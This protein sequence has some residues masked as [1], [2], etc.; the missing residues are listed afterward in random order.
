MHAPCPHRRAGWSLSVRRPALAWALALMALSWLAPG[1]AVAADAFDG[2]P[3]QVPPVGRPEEAVPGRGCAHGVRCPGA[4][5]GPGLCRRPDERAGHGVCRRAAGGR[6]HP[7]AGRPQPDP[8]GAGTDAAGG[9]ARGGVSLQVGAGFAGAGLGFG[10]GRVACR[11]GLCR[12][13]RRRLHRARRHPRRRQLDPDPGP[14]QWP[15]VQRRARAR[16]Q[17]TAAGAGDAPDGHRPGRRHPGVLCQA[18][19][20]AGCRRPRAGAHADLRAGQREPGVLVRLHAAAAGPA[21]RG[22]RGQQRQ[23]HRQ[24]AA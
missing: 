5:A 4:G 3:V 17:R 20:G 18:A 8:K 7:G 13:G 14:G 16:W 10:Q 22:G 24:R 6:A 12:F 2:D 9:T 23:P 19:V 1:A 21:A 15:P 11:R